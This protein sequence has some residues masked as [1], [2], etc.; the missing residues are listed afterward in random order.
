MKKKNTEEQ[1]K[2]L[3]LEK[4]IS[5]V[6]LISNKLTQDYSL[7]KSQNEKLSHY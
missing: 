2:R 4:K 7:F 6:E 5:M 3:D 1:N